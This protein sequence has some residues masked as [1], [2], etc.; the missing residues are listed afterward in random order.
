MFNYDSMSKP[1]QGQCLGQQNNM[2]NEAMNVNLSNVKQ[3]IQ[4]I[5]G[6]HMCLHSSSDQINPTQYD[7]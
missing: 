4:G 7:K 6:S 5:P 1:F 2:T 3:S